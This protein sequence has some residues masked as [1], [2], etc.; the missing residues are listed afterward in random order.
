MQPILYYILTVS[1]LTTFA[2]WV[3]KLVITKSFDIGIER[4]KMTLQKEIEEHKSNL[5]KLSLEH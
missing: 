5:S 2:I 3:G 4:Y 1:G